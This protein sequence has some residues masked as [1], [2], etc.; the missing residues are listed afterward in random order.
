MGRNVWSKHPWFGVGPRAFDDYVLTRFDRELP[1]ANKLDANRRVNTKNENIW[2][3]FLAENGALFTLAFAFVL[4][5]ALWVPRWE[6]ANRLHLGTWIALVLYFAVSGQFSQS[7]LLTMAYAV[8]GI[9][10]HARELTAPDGQPAQSVAPSP[11]RSG[12]RQGDIT[13]D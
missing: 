6:F 2:V 12:H 10:F 9:Y 5:R 7:G 4:V 8:F 11:T 13:M 3:E 1:A